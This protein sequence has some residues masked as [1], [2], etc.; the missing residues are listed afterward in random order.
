[1]ASRIDDKIRCSFCGKPQSDVRK[2]IAGPEGS[3]ICDECV[4]ICM[5]IIDDEFS[6]EEAPFEDEANNGNDLN[7]NLLTPREIKSQVRVRMYPLQE[8]YLVKA[9][10]RLYLR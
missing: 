5:D 6:S 2:M 7:I 4:E 3:Y 9:Y 10:S 8:M 1:M